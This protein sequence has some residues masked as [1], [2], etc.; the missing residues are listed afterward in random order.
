MRNGRYKI[1]SLLALLLLAAPAFASAGG[2]F[3]VK[4]GITI[5]TVALAVFALLGVVLQMVRGQNGGASK[6]PAYVPQNARFISLKKG[7]D[8]S[9]VGEIEG[10]EVEEAAVNTFA[11]QPPDIVG[12]SPI[13]KVLVEVGDT[14]K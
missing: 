3:T 8:L 10:E 4:N 5:A 9:I 2:G 13:P 6:K 14:V 11:V 12:M 7:H 1:Q